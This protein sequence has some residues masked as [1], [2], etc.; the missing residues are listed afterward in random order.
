[1]RDLVYPPVT[2]FARGVFAALGLKFT[3]EGLEHIPASGGVVLS[4]NH[5]S[6]LDFAFLGFGTFKRGRLTRFMA[7]EVVFRHPVSGP[8]MRG[9]H[10]IPV[11]RTAGTQAFRDGVAALK[12]GEILGVFPE[13]TISRS[14]MLK[15]LKPGAARMAQTTGTPI[16][17]AAVWGGQRIYTKGHPKDFT[18][19]GKTIAVAFGEPLYP[20]KR[21]R[22]AE[23]MGELERRMSELLDHVQAVYPDKPSSP[24]DRWWLP[25]CLGGTA[26]TP[27]EA[28]AMDAA[29]RD[30]PAASGVPSSPDDA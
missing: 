29:D 13:A 4:S 11:N 1:V 28:A 15:E 27:Q 23:V 2:V 30:R 20:E 17:P 3:F 8:L 25:A 14:F 24:A 18:G 21:D 19:R 7:K 22:P 26:P 9:M 16:L 5:V 6:Y 10:H 12:A